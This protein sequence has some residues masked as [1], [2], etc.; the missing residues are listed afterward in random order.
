MDSSFSTS[1]RRSYD[2][3]TPETGLAEWTSKIKALQREVD[4]DEEA[5]QKR[6]EEE[7][8]AARQA[9][10]RRS[11]GAGSRA[12]SVDICMLSISPPKNL[13]KF[14]SPND[15]SA[16]DTPKSVM[17]R[18]N[19]QDT[20]LRK[21]MGRNDVYNP[22]KLSASARGADSSSPRSLASFI[23]G[24]ASGPR[25]N[26]LAPQQDAHDP[27][28]FVQPDLSA[29]HPVFGKGGIAM[30][31]LATRHNNTSATSAVGSE[32]SERYQPS[33][34]KSTPIKSPMAPAVNQYTDSISKPKQEDSD[35][36]RRSFTAKDSF[37]SPE[38]STPNT[39]KSE[40]FS[41]TNNRTRN[42]T[43][44]QSSRSTDGTASKSPTFTSSAKEQ[45]SL[46]A[47]GPSQ[48]KPVDMFRSAPIS[49]SKP[50]PSYLGTANTSKSIGDSITRKDSEP[51]AGT[52]NAGRYRPSPGK[53]AVWPPVQISYTEKLRDERPVSPQ[54]T[55]SRERTI[56]VPGSRP[57]SSSSQPSGNWPNQPGSYTQIGRQSPT[58]EKAPSTP[59]RDRTLSGPSNS[60]SS[61]T[62]VTP[63]L[64]RPIQPIPK[65]ASISPLIPGTASSPAFQKPA[66]SKD[67][68]PS[69]SRLQGRGFVQ[70]MVKVSSQLDVSPS[71]PASA[72]RSRPPSASGKKGSVL[73]RWQPHI[74]SPSPTKSATPS[75]PN[76]MRRSATQEPT[77][78]SPRTPVSTDRDHSHTL[79][80]MASLPSLAKPSSTPSPK[81]FTEEPTNLVEPYRSRTPGLGS[82]TTMVL[83]KPSKSATDLKQ[84]AHVDE[85]GVKHDS[86]QAAQVDK[87]RFHTSADPTQ[88]SK[89]PLIHPTKDRA[90]KPKKHSDHETLDSV[91]TNTEE[92][93]SDEAKKASR[94][95]SQTLDSANVDRVQPGKQVLIASLELLNDSK[96]SGSTFASAFA[97]KIGIQPLSLKDTNKNSDVLDVSC[98]LFPPKSSGFLYSGLAELDPSNLPEINNPAPSVRKSFSAPNS[99][100]V[101]SFG[102]LSRTPS[103]GSRP[104]AMQVARALQDQAEKPL[105]N[106]AGNNAEGA[107]EY[108]P[109]PR[110][111]LSQ[112]QAEKR[113]STYEKY[114]AII[115]PPL[116]E[117][118]TPTPTP[119]GTL[120]LTKARLID[121]DMQKV[122]LEPKE[123]KII[124]SLPV[125]DVATVLKNSFS[126]LAALPDQQTISVEVLSITGSTAAPIA[127]PMDIFYESEILTVIHRIKSKSS[128]L[129]STFVWCWLGRRSSFGDREERKLHDLAKHYGTSARIVHQLA[130]PSDL[131]NILGGTLAIRQGSR[132]HWSPDN[133]TM[134][135]ARSLNGVII[136]DEH[137]LNVKNLC[138]A[139]SY[140]LTILGSIYI[141]HGCGS[142]SEERDAALKYAKR[143]SNGT[144]SPTEL[145]DGETDNDE[146]FWMILGDDGFAKADYWKW[147]KS[148]SGGID[149]VIW[150]VDPDNLKSALQPV[151]FI[152]LESQLHQSVYVINCVWE[153]FVFVG[154]DARSAR[155]RIRFALDIASKI[156]KEVAPSRP[157][158]PTVHALALP[159]R[160]PLDLRLGIRD[161]DEAW[162]N[163][164]DIP[165]H[166]NLLSC[167]EA[168]VHLSKESWEQ[169]ALKDHD[170]L[171]LG[172][173]L[174]DIALN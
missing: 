15:T 89:K 53:K 63:S 94:T 169:P 46:K 119:T 149:P 108:P 117:E 95:K 154:K 146:M 3:P 17:E 139:F 87:A 110:N 55:G 114:S 77:I 148:F 162:L 59:V 19:N 22:D 71:P 133:T 69:I 72:D 24:H 93:I 85:L 116:K 36:A 4:A 44:F 18:A 159:S 127:G 14:D 98:A 138:S 27:S 50:L 70:S 96:V 32:L 155:R 74:Q 97:L 172:V 12:G 65:V 68:T 145:L 102:K 165:D 54:K 105:S 39:V 130:E 143:L 121:V 11:R 5:E 111:S 101:P 7:I 118:A 25:L 124:E 82:A 40:P 76:A 135:L 158:A 166:M 84:L 129:A 122:A 61:P 73:D 113:R 49:A 150:R 56:S 92:P 88:S 103:T 28:Q 79:K 29:P 112:A 140:C 1:S 23:G 35:I 64:A 174:P 13:P 125:I 134:H 164:G 104:T 33:S 67:L 100:L 161:F 157:Y 160:I 136:I 120:N 153:L 81:P 8:S 9:R 34:A 38:L 167:A 90:R 30:P 163:N 151:Q 126:T 42:D 106:L 47:S 21:L 41:D 147:R 57:P 45:P 2:I 99:P 52:E 131:V 141:W 156:S 168:V 115:L 10:I 83:I 51:V 107:S 31:G 6:L 62:I 78:H 48:S 137:D 75:L 152:S 170:M 142:T 20:A 43:P 16:N 109:K 91:R 66:P 80:S 26:R 128:G 144:G 132:T 173:G 171:P 60:Q 123:A 37:S 86:G 58:K